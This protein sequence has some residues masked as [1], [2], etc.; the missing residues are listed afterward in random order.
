MGASFRWLRRKRRGISAVKLGTVVIVAA[1]LAGWALIEKDRISTALRPGDIVQVQFAQDYHLQPFVTQVKIAGVPLGV[2]NA[3]SR[4]GDGTALVELKVDEDVTDKLGKT[5]SAA[6]RPTTILGGKYYVDLVPGGARGSFEGTIPVERTKTPVEVQHLAD[7]LQP[8]AV[9]GIQSSTRRLDETLRAGGRSAI[10]RLLADAPGTLDAAAPVLQGMQGLHP[11]TDLPDVVRGL[12]STAHALNQNQGQLD[13]IVLNLQKVSATLDGR[14]AEVA[15]AIG[16]L[17]LTLDNANIG[18][19]RLG[20]TL[21]KL[22]ETADPARPVV[23]ELDTVLAHADPVLARTRPLMTNLRGLLTDVQPLVDQLVPTAQ[24]TTAV[25]DDVRGPVLDRVNGP[26][27]KRVLTPFKGT[28]I[29]AGGGSD[30]PLYKEIGYMF[31]NMDRASQV[32][33]KNGTA[34]GLQPGLGGGSIAG[35]PINF[36]QLLNTLAHL[37]GSTPENREGR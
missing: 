32:V 28:G 35:T 16:S 13:S 17:P 31:A 9:R 14:R 37:Q 15:Q 6:I 23:R 33:D 30:Q 26:I 21:A 11:G 12:E 22:R 3:V 18:L 24:G 7:A 4:S 10:D 2:V 8:D 34:V 19:T 1:L 25:L 20:T 27:M 5:P 36:E 29:Y